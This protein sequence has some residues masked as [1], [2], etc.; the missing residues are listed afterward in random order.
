MYFDEVDGSTQRKL[1]RAQEKI[2]TAFERFPK[3]PKGEI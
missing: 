2:D 1:H 3:K